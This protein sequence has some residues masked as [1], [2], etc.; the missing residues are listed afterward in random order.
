MV[1]VGCCGLMEGQGVNNRINFCPNEMEWVFTPTISLLGHS[2]YRDN[3]KF[4]LIGNPNE[5]E[6]S[7]RVRRSMHT[8]HQLDVM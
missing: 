6:A 5:I 7:D 1:D 2:Q 8:Y 3:Q 4:K